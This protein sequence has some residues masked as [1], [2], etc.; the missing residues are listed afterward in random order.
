MQRRINGGCHGIISK[1]AQGI[2]VDHLVFVVDAAIEAFQ[3][4]QFI[5]IER[6]EAAALDAAKIAAAALYPQHGCVGPIQRIRL[7]DFGARV[8]AAEV[9][10]PQV[11]AQQVRPVAQQFRSIQRA[12]NA[13][14]PAVFEVAKGNSRGH[15]ESSN[16]V[17]GGNALPLR[18]LNEG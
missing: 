4:Q 13:V 1:A 7:Y 5:E 14:I 11:G 16:F 6:G 17:A 2:H 3:P 8:S 12:G 10:D 15:I 9:S 18:N